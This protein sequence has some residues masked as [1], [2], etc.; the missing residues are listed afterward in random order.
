MGISGQMGGQAFH[1]EKTAPARRGA[2]LPGPAKVAIRTVI[3]YCSLHQQMTWYH[4]GD[5][6]QVAVYAPNSICSTPYF[7]VFGN[8]FC[9]H[10]EG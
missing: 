2:R 9:C 1:A 10:S 5:G 6:K 4:W 3:L 8:E 7:E